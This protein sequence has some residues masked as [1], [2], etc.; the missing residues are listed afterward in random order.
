V[1]RRISLAVAA[2]S[3]SALL[4]IGA[5]IAL[6]AP[7]HSSS[8]SV[9]KC[10]VSLTTQP[11][12]GSADV[13]Q[14]AASGSQYGPVHCPASG[15]GGGAVADKFTV[16]DSGN[17]V[18][19]Y[20]EYFATG[21]IKGA[22]DLVPQEAPPPTGTTFTSE[23]FQG[24]VTVTGGTGTLKGFKSAKPGTMACTTPDTVHMTCAEKVKVKP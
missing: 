12:A 18:G 19:T 23:S 9:L 4:A 5:G 11:P 7:A 16:P 2:T 8:V 3:A 1:R 24:T 10:A 6:A 22:F 20:T 17:L 14:P 13:P 15:F 21:T